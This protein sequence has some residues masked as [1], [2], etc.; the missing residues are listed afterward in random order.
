MAY[1]LFLVENS[2][3]KYKMCNKHKRKCADQVF[4]DR[5]VYGEFHNLYK[6]LKVSETRF[7]EYYRMR[8]HT[9]EY[10]LNG[11]RNKINKT[12]TDQSKIICPAERLSITLR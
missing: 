1:K 2:Y 9:F 3:L 4:K 11:I 6:Q 8:P 5:L 7:Y 10:I 12:A